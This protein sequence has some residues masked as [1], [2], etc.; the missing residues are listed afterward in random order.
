MPEASQSAE[1]CSVSRRADAA[2]QRAEQHEGDEGH[3]E[4]GPE[5]PSVDHAGDAGHEREGERRQQAPQGGGPVRAEGGGDVLEEELHEGRKHAAEIARR[6]LVVAGVEILEGRE[7]HLVPEIALLEVV[8]QFRAHGEIVAVGGAQGAIVGRLDREIGRAG[9]GGRGR[10]G[11]GTAGALELGEQQLAARRQPVGD[12]DDAGD[13]E[14]EKRDEFGALA[15]LQEGGDVLAR[16]RVGRNVLTD[17]CTDLGT[18]LRHPTQT[19]ARHV[20]AGSNAIAA[21]CQA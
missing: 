13:D 7:R 3:A 11:D 16:R 10:A 18:D 6:R 9:G 19:P 8:A 4:P 21:I 20:L 1:V 2:G 12:E 17:L 5:R 14:Q 15:D